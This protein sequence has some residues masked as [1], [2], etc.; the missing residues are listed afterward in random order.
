MAHKAHALAPIILFTYNRPEH[1]Q[2]V[3]DCLAKNHLASRSEL[4]IFCDGPKN[5]R[6]IAKNNATR[7]IITREQT[8]G[9]FGTVHV[10]I[11]EKNRGLANSIISGV[12]EII[13]KYKRCIV[14][15]DDL[16]TSKYFLNFMN[17]ALDYYEHDQ[18]IWSITGFSFALKALN[19]YPL[20]VY[21]SYRANSHSWGTWQDRWETVDWVVQDF[22]AL[23]RSWKKR[24]QFNRGGNDLYRMLRHQMRGERDSWAIRFCYSQSKQ[25][26]YTVYPKVSLIK[27]I[28]F[29]GSGTHCQND[30]AI[31]YSNFREEVQSIHLSPLE[32]DPKLAREFKGM[33]RVTLSEAVA[34]GIRKV[35]KVIGR[36]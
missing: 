19:N 16:I 10:R 8:L 14:L 32:L 25:N 27:N 1:T 12:T 34:W 11:S 20:D 17:D 28:G 2:Q 5:E 3:L 4:Y 31:D 33:Y 7:E 35:K 29:D 21:L 23:S 13:G 22:E 18:R 26:R 30:N 6:A 9:R 15:E 24:R 36:K